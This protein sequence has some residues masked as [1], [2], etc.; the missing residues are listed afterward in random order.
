MATTPSRSS[1]V[2]TP[3]ILEALKQLK[4]TMVSIDTVDNK[5]DLN[6]KKG[7]ICNNHAHWI[8]IRKIKGVWYN[9]NSLGM[10]LPELISDFYLS[11]F[12]MGVKQCGFQIFSVEGDYPSTDEY[13]YD[14]YNRNQEWYPAKRIKKYH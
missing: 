12:L 8:A 9:L 7:Y 1:K 11:A 14:H 3:T 6:E 10:K 5:S 13:S 2:R 4:L